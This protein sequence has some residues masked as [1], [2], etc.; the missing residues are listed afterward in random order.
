MRSTREWEFNK[1]WNRQNWWTNNIIVEHDLE[2]SDER[3]LEQSV[4]RNY[5]KT[6]TSSSL[7]Y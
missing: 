1:I 2:P 4:D 3:V 6:E 7:M 5:K